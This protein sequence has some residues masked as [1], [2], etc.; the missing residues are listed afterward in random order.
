M[1]TI[2]TRIR[3]R[4]LAMKL[5]QEQLA[6]ELGVT[7]QTV[8]QWETEPSPDDDRVLST[9]PKRTRLVA[10]AKL[11]GVTPEYLMTGRD[12]E[13]QLVDANKRQLM[14]FYDGMSPELQDALVAHANALFNAS[15]PGKGPANPFGGGEK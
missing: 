5:S 12:A 6:K 7:R 11:L 10:V 4:R 9:A 14:Q 15:N 2:H 13:G 8:Q 1:A 3:E